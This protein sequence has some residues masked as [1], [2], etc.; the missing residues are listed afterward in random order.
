M[1]YIKT[2]TNTKNSLLVAFLGLIVVGCTASVG[3][4]AIH[5]EAEAH[6]ACLDDCE[7]IVS[8]CHLSG[9]PS[10]G[11][12]CEQSCEGLTYESPVAPAH[13]CMEDVEINHFVACEACLFGDTSDGV[14]DFSSQFDRAGRCFSVCQPNSDDSTFCGRNP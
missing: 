14:C 2:M 10:G 3:N 4:P 13:F 6:Q 8:D 7:R 5:S 9:Y 11:R 1:G 12:T